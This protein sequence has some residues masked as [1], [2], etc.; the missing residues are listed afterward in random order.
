MSKSYL[1]K[2]DQDESMIKGRGLSDFRAFKLIFD[3]A[4]DAKPLVFGALALIFSTSGMAILSARL[5]GSLV[6]K[7][8]LAKDVEMTWKFALGVLLCEAYVVFVMW[9]G[10]R[11]LVRGSSLAILRLREACFSK[12]QNLPISYFDRQPQGRVVTRVTHDVESIE[13]FF[14]GS[15]GRL[16]SATFLSIFSL[17][18]IMITS[19]KLGLYVVISLIPIASMIWATKNVIR[20]TN[21]RMSRM[22]SMLNAK[23]SEFLS[24]IEV[25]RAY[26]LESWSKKEYDQGLD[27]Y[28]EAHLKA[29]WLFGLTRPVISF[30]CSLPLLVVLWFGGSAVIAGT[31]AVGLFVTFIRYCERFYHPML[32][33]AMELQAV[34][35]AFTSAER[36]ANFLSEDEESLGLGPDGKLD[37]IPLKG[38]IRFKDVWM[39]YQGD[40]YVLRGLDFHIKSGEM[41]GLVGTT[42]CGK[43]TTVSLLSRLY[44]Y[45][46]GQVLL[47]GIEI[48]DFKRSFLRDQVG[49]VSQDVVIFRGSLRQNLVSNDQVSDEEV[50]R[51]SR[52]TGLLRV[53]KEAELTFESELLEGG[54]NLSNGQRQLI[55][56]TRIL[57]KNPSILILDEA[58]A[59]I[60]PYYESIIHDA[61]DKVMEGRTC[62]IIAHRLAT[63]KSCDR[64]FVFEKGELV[65]SGAPSELLG[66]G[67]HFAKL[68]S[69]GEGALV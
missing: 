45:N 36:V 19:P 16:I 48:K 49:F 54:V 34:Q 5:M 44:P 29:N 25:I 12:L 53:M 46:K 30:A 20:T 62:L 60:D 58:T 28:Q 7:G 21:R 43:T 61:V 23:L 27:R 35:Q 37:Q 38:D 32:M 15:L 40:N 9:V 1:M 13:D 56:L 55:A 66:A 64:I 17:S 47:D 18:A 41:I 33:L 3:H 68:Q 10:R 69:A 42:G 8:L 26:G 65:E 59:N 57:L 39:A 6:D 63:L 2:D 14:T 52:L 50:E 11:L 22:N 31:M 4:A 24:G 67:A 51:A